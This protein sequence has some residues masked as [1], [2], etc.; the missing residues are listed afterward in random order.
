MHWIIVGIAIGIGIMLTPIILSMLAAICT[1]IYYLVALP[2]V[3]L[4]EL[5]NTIGE[6]SEWVAERN[7]DKRIAREKATQP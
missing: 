7:R 1:G 4:W 5:L 6:M 3:F 2:F